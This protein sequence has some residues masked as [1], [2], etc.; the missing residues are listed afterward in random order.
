MDYS[1]ELSVLFRL[2]FKITG[3][4]KD[5]RVDAEARLIMPQPMVGYII[6]GLGEDLEIERVYWDHKCEEFFCACKP[7]DD[8]VR[9]DPEQLLWFLDGIER[10]GGAHNCHDLIPKLKKMV[11][12][13]RKQTEHLRIND[14]V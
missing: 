7:H 3:E 6:E 8:N 14:A 4:D 13:V 5:L 9:K 1:V 12:E 11:E 2:E 10:N